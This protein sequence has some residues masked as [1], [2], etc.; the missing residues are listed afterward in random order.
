MIRYYIYIYLLFFELAY[1]HIKMLAAAIRPE[2]HEGGEL[3]VSK[4]T[5]P[6]LSTSLPYS[7][8]SEDCIPVFVKTLTGKTITLDVDPQD[9]IDTLKEKIEQ[10][11]GVPTSEQRLILAEKQLENGHY[12]SD[13]E[14]KRDC[15]IH[16]VLNLR[17]GVIE[18]SLRILAM[19]YN[20]D[21]LIC[22]KCYA[23]LHSKATNCR[24]RKCGHSN[25]LRPKKKLK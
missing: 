11:E 24:K 22:R 13:Y 9:S 15:T 4:H 10:K 8:N 12:V 2:I 19:K 18:P 20:C 1:H 23:R 6:D 14:I 21:K 25:N 16:L 17:G 3:H 7:S 5:R